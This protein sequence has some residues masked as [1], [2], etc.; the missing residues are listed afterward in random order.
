MSPA[1]MFLWQPTGTPGVPRCVT[2]AQRH[3]SLAC[4]CDTCC[5]WGM[6]AVRGP[7]SGS[8]GSVWHLLQTR[9]G[10][11]RCLNQHTL[12]ISI[13]RFRSG[14]ITHQSKP[15][16]CGYRKIRTLSR[17]PGSNK[18]VL[19]LISYLSQ[20]QYETTSFYYFNCS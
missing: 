15:C 14:I 3:K 1:G 16:C 11:V 18:F 13:V 17:T 9:C 20:C 5:K 10:W 6:M 8:G 2:H 7:S 4:V 19:Y 12:C